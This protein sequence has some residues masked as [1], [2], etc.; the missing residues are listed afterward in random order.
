[1]EKWLKFYATYSFSTSLD[2]CYR[3]TL[4]NT[5]LQKFTLSQE[6]CEKFCQSFILFSSI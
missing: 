5:K 6:N 3:T 2:S 4:L 1:M